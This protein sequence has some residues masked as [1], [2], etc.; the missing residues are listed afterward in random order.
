MYVYVPIVW[1]SHAPVSVSAEHK[2]KN[3]KTKTV[4][5]KRNTIQVSTF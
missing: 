3:K 1:K 4:H 2:T 5:T